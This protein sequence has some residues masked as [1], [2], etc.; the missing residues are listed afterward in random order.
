[1]A[2]KYRTWTEKIKAH[3][4]A[5]Y[6][7]IKQRLALRIWDYELDRTG[8]KWPIGPFEKA[9][10]EVLRF[11]WRGQQHIHWAND[12]FNF[13]R[14]KYA[15]IDADPPRLDIAEMMGHDSNPISL[16]QVFHGNPPANVRRVRFEV[17]KRA[18][19]I[20]RLVSLQYAPESPS[21]LAGRQFEHAF[22]DYGTMRFGKHRPI[23]AVSADGRQLIVLNELSNYKF[24]SRGIVG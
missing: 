8:R 19:K 18:V 22:G 5:K 3:R 13:Y 12:A 15:D 6:E 21:R 14:T 10:D 17:P 24:E 16:Y 1:M 2:K 9:A 4:L 7:G 11:A 20:G 23:L